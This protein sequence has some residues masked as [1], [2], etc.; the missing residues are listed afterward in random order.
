MSIETV[1][2]ELSQ[3]VHLL[4]EAINASRGPLVAAPAPA[5]AA[6]PAYVP[7]PVMAPAP[8]VVTPPLPFAPPPAAAVVVPAPAPVATGAPFTDASGMMQYAVASFQALGPTKG[9]GLQPI[10]NALGHQNLNDIKP[11]QYGQFYAM[12]E[13]LK[14]TP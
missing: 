4:T 9:A 14:A 3:K 1:I 6:A 11:E 13:Q 5:P 7:P 8:A 2:A 10:I 12:V